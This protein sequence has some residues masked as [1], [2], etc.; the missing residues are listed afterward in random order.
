[1]A[2]A[3]TIGEIARRLNWPNHVV[4]YLIRSRRIEPAFRAG[5]LRVFPETIIDQLRQER[6]CRKELVA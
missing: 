4:E 6:S 1:M 5:N 3:L 2:R